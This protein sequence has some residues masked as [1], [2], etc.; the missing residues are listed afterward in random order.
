MTSLTKQNIR[1]SI[2]ALLITVAGTTAIIKHESIVLDA[3]IGVK[4]DVPSIGVGTTIYP[5]GTKVQMGDKIT[6]KQAEEFLK[7]DLNK[8]HKSIQ[9]CVKVPLSQNEY[10]AYIS[11]TYN[12]GGNAFCRSTLVR[13]L[14][15]YDYEG[16][17][18]EILKWDKFKGQPLRGL[19]NRRQ[20]EYDLCIKK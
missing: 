19:T 3:Y 18:K 11:L 1:K 8:F 7:H 13:K 4:G 20:Q 17:C 9:S 14:N 5:D 12:I 15:A 2:A 10:D 16:A 6:R